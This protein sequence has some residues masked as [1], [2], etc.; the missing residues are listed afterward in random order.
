MRVTVLTALWCL[1]MICLHATASATGA[2]N[3]P[4]QLPVKELVVFKDGHAYVIHEG[5]MPTDERGNVV[6]DYLPAP[7]LGTFWAY[8][9]TPQAR[10]QA[11]VAGQR[12]VSLKRTA[13]SLRDLLEANVGAS[14]LI[15][16]T[17]G[18]KYRGVIVG[19]PFSS[20]E[21]QE[22]ISPPNT[23]DKLPVKSNILL[24]RTD[25]GTRAMSLERVLDVTFLGDYATSTTDAEFRNLLTLHLNWGNRQPARRA[26]VGMMYV[27]KGVR[28]IPQYRLILDGKGNA[29]MFLQ[30]S[31]I[32]ELTDFQN[33]TVDL[34]IGVPAF[35][36]KDTRDPIG[37]QQTFAQLS[38]YFRT[39]AGRMLSNAL[40]TQ[41]PRVAGLPGA[42]GAATPPPA[43]DLGPEVAGTGASEDLFVFTVKN[44]SLRKGERMTLPVAEYALKYRDIYTLHVSPFGNVPVDS[45]QP[46]PR[47]AE[48]Q[49]ALAA[50]KVI[51]RVRLTNTTEHPFTTAP[52]LLFSG[53]T[54]LAQDT[55]TYTPRRGTVDIAV[56]TAV[57]I[58]VKQT[59]TELKR[60]AKATTISGV[61]YTLVEMESTLTLTNLSEK[62]VDLE[63]TRQVIGEV[64]STTPEAEV[65]K[66]TVAGRAVTFVDNR[67]YSPAALNPLSQMVWK[68][69]L[70]PGKSIDLKCRWR[71]YTR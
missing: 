28:W 38:Q 13:L 29:K 56:G 43:P 18:T 35:A 36:Y 55:M 46:E 21:E 24:L 10:L 42:E 3:A 23:G 64:E 67:L 44:V 39:D 40:V 37:L 45:P 41:A 61:D 31:L 2:P 49:S 63:V 27:Q 51:H 5:E 60:T 33:A 48:V 26:R 6:M 12:R 1:N 11:V 22:A 70:A 68:F 50:P 32:N 17:S 34:V 8:S 19:V 15:T 7:V 16:E 47:A 62:T 9:A 66:P 69:S 30:A 57:D 14:V 25:E 4:A 54:V 59:D 52:V 65:S 71:Y 20:S 53:D 58:P